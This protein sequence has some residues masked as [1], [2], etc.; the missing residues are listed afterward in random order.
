MG[1]IDTWSGGMIGTLG[2]NIMFALVTRGS[3]STGWE[4]LGTLNF[5]QLLNIFSIVFKIQ[6]D[7]L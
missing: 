4:C 5:E 3:V 1:L 6:C 7:V 2:S